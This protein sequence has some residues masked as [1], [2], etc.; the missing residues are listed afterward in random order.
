MLAYADGAFLDHLGKLVGVSR[1]PAQNARATIRFTLSAV[2]PE[3]TIIRS[4][5]RVTPGSGDVYFVTSGSLEIPS[6]EMSGDVTAVAAV[7]GVEA[8]GFLPG[9]I[10]CLVDP[11]PWIQ[12]VI[13]IT[14]SEGGA[15]VEGDENLRERIQLAPES[16]SNAGSRGAYI[17][18]ARSASQ[19]IAD[20]AVDSPA[21]GVVDIYPL[22]YGGVI[23]EQEILD[24]VLDTC[25][26][27]TVRPMTDLVHAYAPHTVAYDL[28]V[29]WFLERKNATMATSISAAV[30]KAAN[31][32]MIWQRSKLGRDINP[33]E[34][35]ARMMQ[36]GARRVI[37]NLPVFT[38]LDFNM[39][40]VASSAAV[41]YGG[42]EDG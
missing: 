33:S 7:S 39:I 3:V 4:G 18:W 12:S 37:V 36:A 30:A 29:A 24:L 41:N 15:D 20:V 1:L 11:L 9:Q 34:L 17:F 21:P 42:I 28:D 31:D 2:Q 27:D 14:T 8:N 40:G 25:S 26:A 32:W 23:P 16:F 22:L 13:N 5:I 38:V 6:G 10:K 35:I 19:L